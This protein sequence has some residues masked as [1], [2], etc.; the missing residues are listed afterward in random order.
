MVDTSDLK[1]R[2]LIKNLIAEY[3]VVEMMPNF[4]VM[5]K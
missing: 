1:K 2:L 4:T 3:D 5:K